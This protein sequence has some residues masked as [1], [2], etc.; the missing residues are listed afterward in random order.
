MFT[1]DISKALRFADIS[2]A[3]DFWRRQSRKFPLRADGKPNRPMTST[4][5][6]IIEMDEP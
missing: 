6:E 2:L 5:V 3:L 1:A 4:T